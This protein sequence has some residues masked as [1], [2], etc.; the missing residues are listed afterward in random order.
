[1]EE[2]TYTIMRGNF[3]ILKECMEVVNTT[4]NP[5]MF[6]DKFDRALQMLNEASMFEKFGI[7]TDNL[8]SMPPAVYFV[9]DQSLKEIHRPEL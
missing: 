6:F 3:K 7:F 1:M 2:A 4:L 9:A 8:P 5:R